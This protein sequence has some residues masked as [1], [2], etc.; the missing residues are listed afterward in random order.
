MKVEGVL[1]WAGLLGFA[2]TVCGAAGAVETA[3]PSID[4]AMGWKDAITFGIALLGAVLGI[5]NTWNAM[6]ARRVRLRVK[7]AHA[8]SDAGG[9]GFC[10]EIV[11]LSSLPVTV[12]EVGFTLRGAKHR[13]AIVRPILI[14]DKPWPR[15]LE[16]REAVTAYFERPNERGH[17]LGKAYAALSSGEVR[18]GSSPALKQ[19]RDELT[20]G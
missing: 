1:L 4:P 11:N 8:F 20:R 15:R 17:R 3:T 12:R 7:P 14:D 10:I 9:V 5:L 2:L 16:A 18:Y 6:S 19:L 13:A